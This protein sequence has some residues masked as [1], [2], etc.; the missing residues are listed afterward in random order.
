MAGSEKAHRE[1]HVKLSE[2]VRKARSRT[3]SLSFFF[4][5]YL[6]LCIFASFALPLPID[7][8]PNAK[9]SKNSSVL[10]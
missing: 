7:M 1:T 6:N 3:F 9:F 5:I 4:I 8:G 2:K 10:L